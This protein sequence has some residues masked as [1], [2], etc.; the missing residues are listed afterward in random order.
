MELVPAVGR[1]WK[2]WSTWLSVGLA[3]LSAVYAAL[4]SFQDLVEPSLYASLVA[5]VALA[6]KV[7][8]LVK[9]NIP[10]TEEQKQELIESAESAPVKETK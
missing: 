9:Q 1:Q 2:T 8:T 5:G 3:V 10:I 6:I 7:T 4:P